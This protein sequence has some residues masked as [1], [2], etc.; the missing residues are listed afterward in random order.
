[1]TGAK[2]DAMRL[3]QVVSQPSERLPLK[4][5]ERRPAPRAPSR[6]R[7]DP[8]GVLELTAARARAFAQQA[9]WAHRDI[10][11]CAKA[12]VSQGRPAASPVDLVFA[13]D[14]DGRS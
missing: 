13:E 7:L 1:M 6:L 3:Q 10:D 12:L 4:N 5:R 11:A 2:P 14:T 9:D 8:H